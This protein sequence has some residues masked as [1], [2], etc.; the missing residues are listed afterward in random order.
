MIFNG[1]KTTFINAITL[2]ML[3]FLIVVYFLPFIAIYKKLQQIE[4]EIKTAQPASPPSYIIEELNSD[5]KILIEE[6]K[7]REQEQN[8]QL[9]KLIE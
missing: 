4:Q 3:L 7:K 1:K 9:K 8:E 2:I 6:F 5:T